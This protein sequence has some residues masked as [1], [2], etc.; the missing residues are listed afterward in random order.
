[1]K[2]KIV[3]TFQLRVVN[4]QKENDHFTYTSRDASDILNT[5]NRNLKDKKYSCKKVQSEMAPTSV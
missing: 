1:M 5:K 4:F 3:R 2:A